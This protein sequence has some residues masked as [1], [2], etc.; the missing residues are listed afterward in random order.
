MKILVVLPR[1]PYPLEKGDKLRAYHQIV[2]LSK[3][4]EVY[5]F[6][7]SHKKVLPEQLEALKPYCREIKV[8]TPMRL[9][10]YKNVVRNYFF[11]KSLQ[12]GYWDSQSARRACKTFER[13]VQPDVL[14]NQMVRTVPLVARS[15]C[16]K[17]MDFQDALSMN[18]ERRMEQAHGL[19]HYILH[20]EFKMLR[21]TE[22]NAFK[23]F[24]RLTIISES[25][26]DAIPHRQGGNI[27]VIR[28]G[29]DFEYFKPVETEK[30]YDVVF[31]GNMQYRPNVDAAR[32]LVEEVMPLVWEHRPDTQV[33][34]AGA[35]PKASVRRLAGPRVT[36]TGSVDDIR[37]YYAQSKVF[38]APMR[39]GSGL[40][41]K[42]LEAMA[43]GVSC[44]TTPVAN[45][46]LG[47][48]HGNQIMIGNDAQQLADNII[49][50][51]E[52]EQLRHTMAARATTFVHEHFSW[53]TNGQ[54]LEELLKEAIATHQPE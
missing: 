42:L 33:V 12:M 47:A 45:E 44:V 38:A 21:S 46:A 14:Y 43:M 3:R 2:E 52:D 1:F 7:V 34:L 40:Q 16:P 29:V 27:R 31:C 18:T 9:V 50:L 25:D 15:K 48:T 19:W 13:K 32:Y 49:K 36:V 4:N 28:N 22:Y 39:L 10:S 8:V 20:F 11:T 53:E 54:A 37:P 17:V 51:L 26:R 41:N 30:K 5:L 35:T 24:D 23:I 6:A